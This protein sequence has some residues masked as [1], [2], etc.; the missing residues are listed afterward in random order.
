VAALADKETAVKEAR[1]AMD[2]YKVKLD[3]EM[4]KVLKELKFEEK[5]KEA[6]DYFK[7]EQIK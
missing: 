3:L 2:A 7:E 5:I 4:D 1:D 6:A